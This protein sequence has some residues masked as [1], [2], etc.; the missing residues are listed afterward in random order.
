MILTET[1]SFPFPR[2]LPC[3]LIAD[4]QPDVLAALRLLLKVEGVETA[5]ATSPDAVIEAVAARDFD[6]VLMD[7]NYAR[8]T[9]S[10]RE[11]LDLIARLRSMDRALPVVGMT[12]WGS[13]DVAVEAMRRGLDDF[14][15]KPWENARLLKVLR[16]QIEAGRVR[17]REAQRQAAR[18]RDLSSAR[19][20]Q[21]GLIPRQLPRVRNCEIAAS[22]Q[23]A[24]EVSGD[25]FDV[26]PFGESRA[27][28]CIGDVM[29]KGVAAGLLM[30]NVQALVRAFAS[31]AISPD[32]LCARI[33]A[34][35]CRQDAAGKFVTF[36][37]GLLDAETGRLRYANAG[38]SPPLLV[39]RDGRVEGLKQGGP[40]LGV[41]SESVYEPGDVEFARGDRLLLFTDGITEASNASGEE[42]G[43]S[44][45]LD[46]ARAHAASTVEALR[47]AIMRE[48]AAFTVGEPQDDATLLIV[49]S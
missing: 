2:A 38:H 31:E 49:G 34:M 19:D 17:R 20:V 22:W 25:Y 35:L 7:M 24:R 29:G 18:E 9:T 16:E 40:L 12:A 14:V 15:L 21:Q 30:S 6:L 23:P 47:E 43:E 3:A 1:T 37:Y 10:G 33:N 41:F 27:G 26:L 32:E 48:V 4:D 46:L 42:F 13:L 28:L 8:D 36:F 44:R 39:R 45:L 5:T 11:G